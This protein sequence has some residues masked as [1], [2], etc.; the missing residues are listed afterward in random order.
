MRHPTVDSDQRFVVPLTSD[1]DP[2]VKL[3]IDALDTY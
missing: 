3:K 2:S 1:T